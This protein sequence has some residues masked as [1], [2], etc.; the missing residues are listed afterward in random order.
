MKVTEQETPKASTARNWVREL[1]CCWVQYS[2]TKREREREK[3]R[4]RISQDV[5]GP[6]CPCVL[7]RDGVKDGRGGS[8]GRGSKRPRI[9]KQARKH[10]PSPRYTEALEKVTDY[11]AVV[12]VKR[13]Q[14]VKNK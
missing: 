13:T 3:G 14:E 12:Q 10:P 4:K 5:R 8:A 9:R 6:I 7:A 1:G 2:G 11:L